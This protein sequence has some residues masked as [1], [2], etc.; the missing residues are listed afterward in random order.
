MAKKIDVSLKNETSKSS[1]SLQA[2]VDEDVHDH[3]TFR[4]TNYWK[5]LM[6]LAKLGLKD[7]ESDKSALQSLEFFESYL[8]TKPK[9]ESL[10]SLGAHEFVRR[11]ATAKPS[12]EW[13]QFSKA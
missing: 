11:Y 10:K 8:A 2:L 13:F 9:P 12:V 5:E 7:L 6:Q 1:T 3:E 4:N